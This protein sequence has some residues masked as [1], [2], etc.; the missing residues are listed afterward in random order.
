MPSLTGP[1]ATMDASAIHDRISSVAVKKAGLSKDAARDVALHM[2]DWLE[3]ARRFLAFC[4]RPDDYANDA[5]D[6]LLMAFLTHVP[7]HVAAAAKIYADMP[8]SDV[9]GVGAVSSEG[10]DDE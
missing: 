8:V 7:N 9:F 1:M 4:E 6:D 3:D 5:V 2:T 10:N